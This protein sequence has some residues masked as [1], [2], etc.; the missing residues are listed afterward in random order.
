MFIFS[1]LATS[2]DGKIATSNRG[3]FPL[4][5][6]AD[7]K[8]MQ[9]LRKKA[10]AIIQGAGTLRAYRLPLLVSDSKRQP[11]NIVLSSKLEGCISKWGFFTSDKTKKR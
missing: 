10:D 1:N 8:Q 3:H 4:G 6:P 9:V 5:T 11:L 7:R 2:L